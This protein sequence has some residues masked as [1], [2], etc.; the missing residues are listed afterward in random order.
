MH[1]TGTKIKNTSCTCFEI[2]L[3]RCHDQFLPKG[4]ATVTLIF[5]LT[6]INHTQ[7]I[8]ILLQPTFLR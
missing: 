8:D 6:M 5:V 3:C 1:G 2:V 4:P 7:V